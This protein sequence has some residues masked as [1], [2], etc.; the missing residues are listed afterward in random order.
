MQ[1]GQARG[2][3]Y[4]SGPLPPPPVLTEPPSSRLVVIFLRDINAMSSLQ[5]YIDRTLLLYPPFNSAH[6]K[7]RPRAPRSPRRTRHSRCVPFHHL[8]CPPQIPHRL[9]SSLF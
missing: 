5:G 7:N 8:S 2:L 4:S 1:S 9:F 3:I 6:A